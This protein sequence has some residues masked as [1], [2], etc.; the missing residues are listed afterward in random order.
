[1]PDLSFEGLLGVAAI[2]VLAP[3]VLELVGLRIPPVVVEIGAGIVVG[4]AVLGWVR[5]DQVI[6][7]VALI[8]LALLLFLAGLEVDA[9]GLRGRRLRLSVGG[10]A[11]SVVL[12]TIV[13]GALGGLGLVDAPLI[14]GIALLAT[15]LGVVIPIVKDAGRA[16]SEFGQ[17]VL[18]AASIADVGAIVALS[19][20]VSRDPSGPVASILLLALFAL[21]VAVLAASIAG[22]ERVG[23]LSRAL[24]RLQDT[25]ARIRVRAA[26]LLVVGLAVLAQ[27]LGLEVI[28]GAFAAGAIVAAIDHDEAL[29]HPRFRDRLESVGFGVFIPVF[30]VTTG[31]RFD[32]QALVAS[33]MAL[34]AVPLFLAALLLVRG[35]P[36]LLYRND[37]GPREVA[38]AGLLQ[39]TSL[40]FIVTATT[41][42]VEI[43]LMAPGTASGL[44][45]AGLASVLLFPTVAITLLGQVADAAASVDGDSRLMA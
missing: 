23:R 34:A 41:V 8:G 20:V 22:F 31:L 30:F 15:S 21:L 24:V 3:L 1:V 19:L 14:A 25:T 2:A 44:V 9:R 38:A 16:D 10:F 42:A 17:L 33:P 39:A 4:P 45:A 43:G 13:T 12:A 40:P 6:E 26:F 37:A 27:A 29:T 7:V 35:V 5:P 11:A 18:A 36:A 28:L 32:L